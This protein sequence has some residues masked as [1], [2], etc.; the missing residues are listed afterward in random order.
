VLHPSVPANNLQEF[1]AL[2][3]SKPGELNYGTSGTGNPNHLATELFSMMT[4]IKMQHVPY[5]G[6][7]PAVVDLLSGRVQVFLSVPASFIP[8]IQSGK[9]KAIGITGD[10]RMPALPQVPTFAESGLSSFAP[11]GWGGLVAPAG[12]PKPIIDKLASE[13]ARILSLPDTKEKF[14][15]QGHETFATTPEEFATLMRTDLAKYSNI[16][17]TANIKIEQ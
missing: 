15:A 14:L 2:A 12:T 4:G 1:I 7:A 5:K 3:K 16:I 8:Y 9:L 17:N 11:Q 6:A 13:I 10:A